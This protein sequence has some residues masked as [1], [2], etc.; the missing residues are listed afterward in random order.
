MCLEVVTDKVAKVQLASVRPVTGATH[1]T[2]L[3]WSEVL[4]RGTG[5]HSNDGS[6]LDKD[7]VDC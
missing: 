6:R 2:T 5:N 3:P 4:K 7:I 1:A